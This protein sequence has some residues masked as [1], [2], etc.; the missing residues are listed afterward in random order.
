MHIGVI[1]IIASKINKVT[2]Q[3]KINI[4]KQDKPTICMKY[5]ILLDDKQ[6]NDYLDFTSKSRIVLSLQY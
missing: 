3:T 1:R 6:N 2:S 4:Y 5:P